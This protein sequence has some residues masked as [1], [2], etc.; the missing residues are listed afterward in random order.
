MKL[1]NTLNFSIVGLEDLWVESNSFQVIDQIDTVEIIEHPVDFANSSAINPPPTLR[2]TGILGDN[3]SGVEIQAVLNSSDFSSS[4][5]TNVIT[6]AD[7]LAIFD[8]LI[9]NDLGVYEIE[10]EVLLDSSFNTISNSFEIFDSQPPILEIT[11]PIND[12]IYYSNE[13][14]INFNAT[15]LNIIDELFYFNGAD[16]ITY[17]NPV[18]I[19]LS[20]GDYEFIF[21]ARD[22]FGL[23]SQ[24]VVEFEV[25]ELP[26]IIIT[27]PINNTRFIYDDIIDIEWEFN[28]LYTEDLVCTI[29]VN[30]NAIETVP[31]S[32]TSS[33][34]FE[35]NALGF[36]T[37]E[38]E[39]IIQSE[40]PTVSIPQFLNSSPITT[41]GIRRVHLV[42]RKSF[43]S[44]GDSMYQTFIE[45]ENKVENQDIDISIF[46]FID[47]SININP[48][49]FSPNFTSFISILGSLFRGELFVVDL[50]LTSSQPED[51]ITNSIAGVN[52]NST[53]ATQFVIGIG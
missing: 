21:Y 9:I 25:R 44:L 6:N 51:I 45:V 15:S 24:E 37:S 40:L 28:S 43:E 53:L 11:S 27:N 34:S 23:L 35:F 33:N 22:I 3:L 39:I 12:A 4:S 16:N 48:S 26:E 38:F 42:A 7:G 52:E 5:T 36:T 14:E 20:P 18:N 47:E 41:T 1:E 17:T 32:Q 2:V 19:T 10:F 30:S 49:S 50:S 46:E 29:F 13:I 8:N 31:C